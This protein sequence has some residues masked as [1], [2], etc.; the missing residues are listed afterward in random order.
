MLLTY[1]RRPAFALTALMGVVFIVLAWYVL[2]FQNYFIMPDELG[3]MRNALQLGELS[4]SLRGDFWFNN[5]SQFAQLLIA[6]A[7][8]AFTTP[9]AFDASHLISAAVMTTTA[10]PTYLL[11]RRIG[12]STPLA[13]LAAAAA[14]VVPWVAMTASLMTEPVAYCVFAWTMLAYQAALARPG[15]R[16]DLIAIGATVV[17]FFT[18]TQFA[19]LAGAL[20]AAVVAYELLGAWHRPTGR[21]RAFVLDAGRSLWR[22]HRVVIT[23]AALALLLALLGPLGRS[24][25][26][27]YGVTLRGDLLPPGIGSILHNLVAQVVVAVGV[28]PAVALIASAMQSLGRNATS[29]ERAFGCVAIATTTVLLLEVGSFAIRFAAGAND[30]YV[31]YLVPLCAVGLATVLRPGRF[32][33]WQ[34]LVAGAGLAWLIATSTFLNIGASLVAVTSTYQV[35]LAGH[36]QQVGSALGI[37]NLSPEHAMAAV[38]V[39]LVAACVAGRRYLPN[40]A[41]AV[42]TG[43]VVLTWT[44]AE[45]GYTLKRIRDTQAGAPQAFINARDWLDKALPAD[46]KAGIVLSLVY[47]PRTTMGV[48]WDTSFWSKKGDRVYAQTGQPIYEQEFA[49]YF[50]LDPRTGRIPVLDARPWLVRAIADRRFDLIGQRVVASNGTLVLVKAPRPYRASWTLAAQ[51]DAGTIVAGKSATMRVFP[52]RSGQTRR[53]L[54]LTFA[55]P[56]GVAGAAP[57]GVTVRITGAGPD[58]ERT[59]RPAPSSRNTVP[60]TVSL[61]ATG[62][63]VLKI[64]A[65]RGSAGLQVTAVG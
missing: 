58:V 56:P 54:R 34:M 20:G 50:D 16:G 11:T 49:R 15:P 60:V 40:W 63:A 55:V 42:A 64:R 61:P 26:G 10:I 8:A 43:A 22:H 14:I 41:L 25:L 32:P 21:R 29:E 51:D 59:I 37:S 31:V 52:T 3:Y 28:L 7:Y 46:A 2:E 9:T 57:Q 53:R 30:R 35:V 24:S 33:A 38:S 45:T 36:S 1:A 13:L 23:V 6:P 17:A 18:R 47:D 62:P 39:V 19:A 27:A 48:Y 65:P 4:P 44:A 5:Y 12:A